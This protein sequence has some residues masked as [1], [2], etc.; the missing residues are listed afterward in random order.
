MGKGRLARVFAVL[1]IRFALAFR[2]MI[3]IVATLEE[4]ARSSPCSIGRSMISSVAAVRKPVRGRL[5]VK[6]IHG[7]QAN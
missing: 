7:S 2:E 5:G 1:R 4:I 3:T 6:R